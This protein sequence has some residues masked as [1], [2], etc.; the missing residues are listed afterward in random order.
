MAISMAYREVLKHVLAHISEIACDDFVLE[1]Q[2]V[3]HSVVLLFQFQ[4]TF[5]QLPQLTHVL[6]DNLEHII[7]KCRRDW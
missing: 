7:R 5:V 3:L 6:V 1:L 4:I 2:C